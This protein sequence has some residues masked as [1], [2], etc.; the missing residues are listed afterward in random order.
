MVHVNEHGR[1]IGESHPRAKISDADVDR[2]CEMADEAIAGGRPKM[3]V[4]AWLAEKFEIHPRTVKKY[5]YGEKR[6]Q[7]VAG[8]R[9]EFVKFARAMT[10]ANKILA[11]MPWREQAKR[12]KR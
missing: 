12:G 3:Q 8:A 7:T 4:Y 10:V 5:V 11:D 9:R 1:R 2:I 6:A